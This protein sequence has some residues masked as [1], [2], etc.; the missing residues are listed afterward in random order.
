MKKLNNVLHFEYSRPYE[1]TLGKLIGNTLTKEDHEQGS[2]KAKTCQKIWNKYENKIL[3]LFSEIYKIEISDEKI[4][5]YISFVLPNS[6][7]NPLTISLKHLPNVETDVR[8]QRGLVYK[9]IHE[10]AHYFIYTRDDKEFANKL[11]DKVRKQ[12]ILGDHGANLHYLIQ[13]VEFGII[14][15]VFGEEYANYDREWIIKRWIDN[16]YGKSAKRLKEDSVPM[17]KTCLEYINKSID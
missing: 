6:F 3:K 16:E 2:E 4:K 11:F 15:E 5:A 17:N 7:S 12:N 8:S 9:V 1:G 14:S 10:L 13:A